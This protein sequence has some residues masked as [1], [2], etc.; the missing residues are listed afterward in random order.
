MQ[1][2]TIVGEDGGRHW[3]FGYE[4]QP[5][6]TGLV[7]FRLSF[8]DLVGNIGIEVTQTTDQSSVEMDTTL[9]E[10]LND[11]ITSTNQD[12]NWAKYGDNIT[13]SFS[14]SEP[15]QDPS[16]N[17]TIE[18]LTDIVVV[19][20]DNLTEWTATGQVASN[21]AGMANYSISVKDLTGNVAT[22]V[23]S[24]TS[25]NLDTES[26]SLHVVL[27]SSNTTN[28]SY[29]KAG[30]NLTLTF[31]ASELIETPLVTLAGYNLGVQDTNR[32]QEPLW[33]ATYTVQH[34]D[35]G[36]V[37]FS[38]QYQDQAG[39]TG[40]PVTTTTDQSSVNV[41]TTTPTLTLVKLKSN[42]SDNTSLAKFGDTVTLE[43]DASETIEAP[44]VRI[45]GIESTVS[46]GSDTDWMATY[47]VPDYRAQVSTIAGSVGNKGSLNGTGTEANFDN[48]YFITS[49]GSNLY[50]A[51]HNNH[52][53][54]KIVISSG[55]V[56]TLAGTS[57]VSGSNDGI[58]SAAKFNKPTGITTDGTNLYVSEWNNHTIRKINIFS[59]LVTTFAGTVGVSGTSNGTGTEAKFKNPL[60]LTTDGMNLFVADYG[61]HMI[62]K[63]VIS[64]G[65][66]TTL[67]GTAGVS[68]SIDGTGT[69]AKF[70][71]P[72]D[73][74]SV[75]HNLY[76]ST[77]NHTIRKIVSSNG[78]VTTLAGTPGSYGYLDGKGT[79]AKFRA[80]MASQRM[81]QTFMSQVT[82]IT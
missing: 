24:T 74:V 29:A 56:T 73:L 37:A 26:P 52:T 11:N 41:D 54:R 7:D 23:T 65:V 55:V 6:D 42:N 59:G 71:Q 34:G 49:D 13:L 68:G 33:Q 20:S 14:T 36:T 19:G 31:N 32:E 10:I 67:A 57:G 48:P 28:S 82:V 40:A 2:F 80:L 35:N 5:G 21:A 60:G 63:V 61:N 70:K 30:D 78:V 25:I 64:S 8:M 47:S 81:E 58:G 4:I 72:I 39:N 16:D 3:T 17:I 77:T 66:V 69:E 51:D 46:F 22:P 38:I 50:V 62:R 1:P 45:N 75:D 76:V 12:P 79:E 18:G 43:F 44:S 27:S 9:P 15:I 53:I